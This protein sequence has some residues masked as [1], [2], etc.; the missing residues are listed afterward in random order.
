MAA[1]CNG[2]V[3]AACSDSDDHI[4]QVALTV[5]VKKVEAESNVYTLRRPD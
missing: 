2:G 1:P 5:A 4:R 3:A